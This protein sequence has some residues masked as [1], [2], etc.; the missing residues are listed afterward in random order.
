MTYKNIIFDKAEGIATVTLNRP[1]VYNALNNEILKELSSVTELIVSD[2]EIK[3]L[4]IT[5]GDKVFASGGDISYIASADPLEAEQFINSC[6]KAL[7][8]M[9]NLDIPV[10]ASIAGLALG[11]GCEIALNCDVRIAAEGTQFGLPEINLGIPPAL[12]VTQR[13]A[14][15]VG[16]GWAKY[17]IMTGRLID[18]D[19]ALKIGLITAVYPRESLMTEA[20]KLAL[21]LAAKPSIALKTLKRSIKYCENVDFPSD[22]IFEENTWALL[23]ADDDVREA[24][25][26]FLEKRK[27][28][29]KEII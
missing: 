29:F 25:T 6:H 14:R 16:T 1:K 15:L 13:L 21:E 4:I 26:A 12:G 10:I 11:G 2:K 17:M 7:D 19:T 27:A 8:K 18:T 22:L 28:V 20:R 24:M 5:G 3:V 9:A 23:F